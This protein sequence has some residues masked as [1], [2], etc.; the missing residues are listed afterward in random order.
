[1][2]GDMKNENSRNGDCERIQI[3]NES[4]VLLNYFNPKQ[5]NADRKHLTCPRSV[6]LSC[7]E[8][9][10][11]HTLAVAQVNLTFMNIYKAT[12]QVICTLMLHMKLKFK[13]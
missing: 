2:P 7:S 10:L 13:R 4:E 5:L 8:S 6:L 1:M 3:K 9:G 12:D 11:G